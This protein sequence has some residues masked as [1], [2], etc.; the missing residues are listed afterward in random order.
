MQPVPVLFLTFTIIPKQ[1]NPNIMA[2]FTK[3]FLD[4]FRELSRNNHRDWF[5]ANKKR[6]ETSVKKPFATFIQVMID[7]M[8]ADDP[9]VILTPKDAIFRINRDIRFSK[10]KT[11]YKTHMA[12]IISAGGK[13]NKTV[14]GIYLQFGAEETR[15][16]SGA[17]MLEKDQ[18]QRVREAIAAHPEKFSKLVNDKAFNKKFGEIHGE[19]NKRLPKEFEEA[20]A[21]Q[22][23][24][25][26]KSFYYF[27]QFEPEVI[28]KDDLADIIMDYW[29][30]AKPLGAFFTR[31]ISGEL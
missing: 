9:N 20:A 2:F 17:H 14:P 3:D 7:R 31:A 27:H 24:L 25:F 30:T 22:P 5:Q 19:E 26:K 1:S 12:A 18:L 29:M 15:L 13:K 10:D 21:R 28:L 4:F 11:P 16:Y 8:Q 6:Y 23:L